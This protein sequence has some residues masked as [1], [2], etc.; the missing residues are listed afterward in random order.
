[1]IIPNMPVPNNCLEC[2]LRQSKQTSL[3]VLSHC[4]LGC[5]PVLGFG[6]DHYIASRHPDCPLRED[7]E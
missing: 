1:M 7:K 6:S 5:G 2:K 4:T 3:G